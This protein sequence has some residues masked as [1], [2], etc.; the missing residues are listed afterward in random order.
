MAEPIDSLVRIYR[1]AVKSL[2]RDLVAGIDLELGGRARTFALIQRSLQILRELDKKTEIWALRHIPQIYRT[3]Q[4]DTIRQLRRFGLLRRDVRASRASLVINRA[5]IEALVSAPDSGLL[6][7]MSK[8][9]REIKDRVKTIQTQAKVLRQQQRLI[10]ETIARVGVLEGQNLN[11]VR[12]AIVDELVSAKNASDL[13]WRPKLRSLGQGNILRNMVDLPFVRIPTAVGGERHLRVDDYASLVARTKTRQA[14]TLARRAKLLQHDQHLVKI[15]LNKPLQDDACW[16]YIGKVF[17]LT[18][19][20]SKEFGVPHVNQLP[21]GGTPFHPNCTHNEVGFF[22]ENAPEEVIKLGL[23]RP[24]E[25]ALNRSWPQVEKEFRS[26]GGILVVKDVN[27]AGTRFGVETG[28]RQ[29]RR[30]QL[31]A[32]G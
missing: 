18:T 1:E 25:W 27:R 15:T 26:R 8:A 12:D 3:A 23:Q 11:E 21:S 31:E 2:S 6:G 28:G 29:R 20:A 24:P 14:V 9:T 32:A 30:A 5:A 4:K 13:V 22:I 7:L 17:A 16:L 10:N 19:T